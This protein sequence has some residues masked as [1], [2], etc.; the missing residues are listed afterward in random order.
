M[1]RKLRAAGVEA[2]L[3]VW[4]GQSHVQWLRDINAPETKEYHEEVA[5]FFDLHL[6]FCDKG[7][8]SSQQRARAVVLFPIMDSYRC[9]G[10]AS[11][12]SMI[13]ANSLSDCAPERSRPLMKKAGV[14]WTPS[15]F[16]SSSSLCT[17][18]LNFPVSRHFAK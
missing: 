11:S 2:A 13:R 18:V 4:E 16:P 12:S 7:Q 1:H 17:T 8:I 9:A 14:P 3:Q 5:R 10:L 15:R 6:T